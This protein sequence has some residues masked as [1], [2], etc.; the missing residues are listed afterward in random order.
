MSHDLKYLIA[1]TLIL[2]HEEKLD[3][4][5][6]KDF[7]DLLD[8]EQIIIKE[9]KKVLSFNLFKVFYIN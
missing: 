8:P 2:D 6:M 1:Q 4:L 3:P 9:V 7:M 5:F